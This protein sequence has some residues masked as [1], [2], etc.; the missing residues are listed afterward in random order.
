MRPKYTKPVVWPRSKESISD[1]TWFEIEGVVVIEHPEKFRTDSID[2][3]HQACCGYHYSQRQ[4]A[5]S[6]RNASGND[7]LHHL[8]RDRVELN[9]N[10]GD[11]LVG[12]CRQAGDARPGRRRA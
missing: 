10:N 12:L 8:V 5:G 6:S 1:A 11:C 4:C 9:Q 7:Q 2:P 3:A